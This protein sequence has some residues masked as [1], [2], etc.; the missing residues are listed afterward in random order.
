MRVRSARSKEPRRKHL[1]KKLKKKNLAKLTG[2]IPTLTYTTSTN[3]R[4]LVA[5]P[6]K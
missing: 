1:N 5:L 6:H 4:R 3:M 2:A